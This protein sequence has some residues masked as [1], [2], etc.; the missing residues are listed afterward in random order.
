MTFLS[1]CRNFWRSNDFAVP[2]LSFEISA[3]YNFQHVQH[4]E[5]NANGN[6]E[7]SIVSFPYSFTICD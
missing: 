1:L 7:V 2:A 4:I 6:F 5:V 3:P